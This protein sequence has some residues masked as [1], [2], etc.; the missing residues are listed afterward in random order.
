MDVLQHP[1]QYHQPI[2]IVDGQLGLLFAV[3]DEEGRLS[4]SERVILFGGVTTQ[5]AIVYTAAAFC[6]NLEITLAHGAAVFCL[7]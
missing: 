2:D 7:D 6:D 3:A 4:E 5:L 1:Q